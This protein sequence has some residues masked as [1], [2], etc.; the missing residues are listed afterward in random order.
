M[1]CYTCLK[2]LP[3]G[4]AFSL[5]ILA[6]ETTHAQ[7]YPSR[8]IRL[9]VP[10]APGGGVDLVSRALAERLT[11]TLGRAVVV[12]NRSGG[13][14]VVGSDIVAK[15][16]P[17]GY[18]LLVMSSAHSINAAIGRALPYDTERDFAPIAQTTNQLL[19]IVAH[20]GVPVKNI[21][22]LIAYSK[23]NPGKLNYGSS[24]N[25][26]TLPMELFK[27]MTGADIE[28]IPYKGTA[29]MLNDLLGGHLQLSLAGLAGSLQYIKAGRL[30]AL[31][32][33]DL[34]R[35]PQLPDVPTIAEQGVAGFRGI[36]WTAALFA[37]RGT[38]KPVIAR[39]HHDILLA[40]Q[41]PR[42]NE[43]MS[44]AGFDVVTE[45]NQPEDLAK[46]VRDDIVRWRKVAKA[47]GIKP[48]N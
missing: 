20:P 24:S 32:T 5:A 41:H 3:P 42:L 10:Y 22:E 43:R 28:H 1:R 16:T 8:P 23:S 15:A 21:R 39:L 29:P 27:S 37:P 7:T 12:D 33:G 46:L 35:T 9:V 6:A 44:A 25:A 38:S 18:T 2:L 30:R 13:E 47:A 11:E 48:E 26:V 19:L 40:L 31:G 17:D 36:I 34:K 14:N 45:S 4:I